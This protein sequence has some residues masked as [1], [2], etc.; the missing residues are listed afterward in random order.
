MLKRLDSSINSSTKVPLTV[1]PHPPTLGTVDHRS[2][3]VGQDP[4]GSQ[5]REGVYR[6]DTVNT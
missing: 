2:L 3:V 5:G 4:V 1:V 6:F